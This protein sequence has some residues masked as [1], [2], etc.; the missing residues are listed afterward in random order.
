MSGRHNTGLRG[1]R[2]RPLVEDALCLDLLHPKWK[3]TLRFHRISGTIEWRGQRGVVPRGWVDFHLNP[4]EANRSRLLVLDFNRDPEES[5]QRV[6]LEETQVG[7]STR[8]LARCPKH[9]ERRAQKIYAVHQGD[10]FCCWRCS[11]LTHRSAQQHDARI[12]LALRDP[13]GFLDARNRA[14][15]TSHSCR[16]TSW[17]V[18]RAVERETRLRKGRGWGRKSITAWDRVVAEMRAEYEVRP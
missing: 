5:K 7:I 1:H 17:L 16:V 15:Q 18:I 3:E 9:C 4:I 6:I 8:W 11:G 14:P 13:Q 12:D 10:R 2:R